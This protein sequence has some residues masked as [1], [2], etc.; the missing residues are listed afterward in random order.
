MWYLGRSERP[1]PPG[2]VVRHERVDV[3]CLEETRSVRPGGYSRPRNRGP[4]GGVYYWGLS[5]RR[6]RREEETGGGVGVLG[7]PTW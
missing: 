7:D 6:G 3:P 2:P 5:G 1:L 4:C